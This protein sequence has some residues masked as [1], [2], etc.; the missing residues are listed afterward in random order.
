MKKLVLLM[1][2]AFLSL[3]TSCEEDEKLVDDFVQEN[4]IVGKWYIKQIGA[5]NNLNTIVYVDY[6]NDSLCE[7][8]NLVL[9]EN[10]TFE[11][12]SFE[13]VG[14]GCE[15]FKTN[16]TYNLDKNILN[17]ITVNEEGETETLPLSIISLT[18]DALNISFTD[19]DTGLLVF[20][21]LEK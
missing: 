14:L 18:Y 13:I 15:N 2:F 20:L 9:T 10:G 5:M 17:L 11:E 4:Y 16:G 8:D 7:E 12:N 3:F 19:P 6:T 1:S 21:K